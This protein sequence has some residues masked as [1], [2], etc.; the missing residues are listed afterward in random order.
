[1]RARHLLKS[2]LIFILSLTLVNVAFAEDLNLENKK[3]DLEKYYYTKIDGALSR[4]LPE[5]NYLLSVSVEFVEPKSEKQTPKEEVAEFEFP[6]SKLGFY[7]PP[8]ET[9]QEESPKGREHSVQVRLVLDKKLKQTSVS[10]IRGILRS[11]VS[12]LNSPRVFVSQLDLNTP[13]ELKPKDDIDKKD[14][15]KK[16]RELAGEKNEKSKDKKAESSLLDNYKIPLGMVISSLVIFILGLFSLIVYKSSESKKLNL[17]EKQGAQNDSSSQ[18]NDFSQGPEV[19]IHNAVAENSQEGFE[20]EPD[21][22]KLKGHTQFINLLESN[23]NSALYLIKMWLNNEP[24]GAKEGL[25][26]LSERVGVNQLDKILSELNKEERKVWN[27][28]LSQ[29]K[30]PGELYA[31]DRFLMSET[32]S[33]IILPPPELKQDVRDLVSTLSADD[34]TLIANEKPQLAGMLFNIIPTPQILKVMSKV[35]DDVLDKITSSGLSYKAEELDNAYNELQDIMKKI[36][37]KDNVFESPLFDKLPDILVNVGPEK[38]GKLFR[39]IAAQGGVAQV[40]QLASQFFPAELVTEL[41]ANL[42]KAA[43]SQIPLSQRAELLAGLDEDKRTS[44]VNSFADSPKMFEIIGMEIDDILNNEVRL[45]KAVKNKKVLWQGFLEKVRQYIKS[46]ED[47]LEETEQVINEWAAQ[48][49]EKNQ[50]GNR[51]AS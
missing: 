2:I 43:L 19:S 27:N 32:L 9:K 22:E 42:V 24:I 10:R 23:F 18:V 29:H 1:M 39:S 50:G 26:S 12:G 16:E 51:N 33:H 37:K 45:K 3:I 5:K 30:A 25:S 44:L 11:Q 6:I 31:A 8:D 20:S 47:L 7:I 34:I 21:G 36:E 41:P 46:D 48:L 14:I 4:V 40:K 13:E 28:L 17:L 49:L 38:E 35:N 15:E